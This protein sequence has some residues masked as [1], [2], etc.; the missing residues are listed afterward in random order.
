M[1]ALQLDESLGEYKEFCGPI[2]AQM[3]KL[4]AERRAPLNVLDVMERRLAVRRAT[5]K[6][7]RAWHENYFDTSD[8]VAYHPSGKFKIVL[9]AP[10]LLGIGSKSKLRGGA[11]VLDDDAYSKLPGLEFSSAD[12]K[13]FDRRLTKRQALKHEGLRYL[14]RGQ[15]NAER[16]I[17]AIFNIGKYRYDYTE[18]M[19][20]YIS[21]PPSD[22][23]VMR[24]WHAERIG[25]MAGLYGLTYLD[26]KYSHLVGVTAE[27]PRVS[28]LPR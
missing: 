15:E 11:L 1:S 25:L 20:L 19:G 13:Y 9:D 23:P 10:P 22:S 28:L 16:I 17:S 27:A 24:A 3:P 6:V 2:P 12:Q 18:M 5:E 8:G 14:L 26:D 7:R 21:N 4:L